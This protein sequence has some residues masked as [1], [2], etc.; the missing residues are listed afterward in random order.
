M[1]DVMFV[2]KELHCLPDTLDEKSHCLPYIEIS[3]KAN[4]IEIV[5]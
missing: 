4:A 1:D 3:V 5:C 2:V